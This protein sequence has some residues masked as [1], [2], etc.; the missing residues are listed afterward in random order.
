MGGSAGRLLRDR[1]GATLVEFAL[2]APLLLM[3]LMGMLTVAIFMFQ[4]HTLDN[5]MRA[6]VRQ[7][8]IAELQDAQSISAQIDQSL[9][10][11]GFSSVV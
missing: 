10:A 7:V 1:A 9:D 11:A 2:V 8:L 3:V 5:T 6:A 4:S